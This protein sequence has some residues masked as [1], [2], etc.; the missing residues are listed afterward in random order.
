[1]FKSV[2]VQTAF[3][4]MKEGARFVDVRSVAEF[5]AGHPKGAVNIPLLDH[6]AN[7]RMVPNPQFIA[8]MQAQFP[9]DTMLLMGCKVG[10]RSAHACQALAQHGYTDL[11]NVEGGF[12][13]VGGWLDHGLPSAV[14][15]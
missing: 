15:E 2:D 7:G 5:R 9:T 6:D 11:S 3:Q 1:M 10:G 4:Q 14:G 8:Q 13:A 12:L